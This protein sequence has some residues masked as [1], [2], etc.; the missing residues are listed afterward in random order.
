MLNSNSNS[1]NNNSNNN[2]L[3]LLAMLLMIYHSTDPGALPA[4]RPPDWGGSEFECPLGRGN[5]H[6]RFEVRFAPLRKKNSR[7]V[8]G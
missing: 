4:G 1:N 8:L 7:E 5:N 3:M 2:L 6:D